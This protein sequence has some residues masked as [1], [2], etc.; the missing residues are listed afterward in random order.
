MQLLQG[1][2][3]TVSML[4][5]IADAGSSCFRCGNRCNVRNLCLDRSLAQVA[6]IMHAVLADRGIDDQLDIA[7]CDDIKRIRA[8]LKELFY[9]VGR[10]ACGTDQVSPLRG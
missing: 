1:L 6:V 5:D 8:A 2:Q 10:N 4:L 7:V 9:L 3:L